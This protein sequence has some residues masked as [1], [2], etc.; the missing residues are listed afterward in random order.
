MNEEQR[1]ST[2]L[3]V[4]IWAHTCINVMLLSVGYCSTE[5]LILVSSD[6][7]LDV[8]FLDDSEIEDMEKVR[9][10][11]SKPISCSDG[12]PA[13]GVRKDDRCKFAWFEEGLHKLK[14]SGDYDWLCSRARKGGWSVS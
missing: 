1:H 4:P 10:I 8:I 6:F 9:K 12:G 13:L 7:Q 5:H 3:R 14:N 11:N 2:E